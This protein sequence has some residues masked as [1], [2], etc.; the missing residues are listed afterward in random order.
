MAVILLGFSAV[1]PAALL[2]AALLQPSAAADVL[3][4]YPERPAAA[5]L[6]VCAAAALWAGLAIVYVTTALGTRE[7]QRRLSGE[8]TVLGESVR[9]ARPG[10]LFYFFVSFALVGMA[11][12]V[13]LRYR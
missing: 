5:A 7:Q 2:H 1:A 12:L 8:L 13:A 4:A 6:C 9:R 10:P 3:A 11:A